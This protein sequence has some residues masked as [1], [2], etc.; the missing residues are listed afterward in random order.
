LESTFGKTPETYETEKNAM[1][2]RIVGY[3]AIF[4]GLGGLALLW[5]LF[6]FP[7]ACCVAGYTRSFGATLNPTVGLDTIKRLGGDYAKVLAMSLIILMASAAVSAGLGIVFNAFALPGVGNL[8]AKFIGSLFGFYLS[9][10][11]SCVLGFAIYKAA[12]RLQLPT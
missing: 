1:W 9:V 3:G 7:A 5:G 6:Y 10:V 8:P 4:L 11:F 12:D 2:S